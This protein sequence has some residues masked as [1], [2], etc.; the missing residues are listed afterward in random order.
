MTQLIYYPNYVSSHEII[1]VQ[2]RRN[3]SNINRLYEIIGAADQNEAQKSHT[4]GLVQDCSDYSALVIKLLQ[5]C[6]KTSI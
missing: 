6:S 5:S 2:R 3:L 1:V 4:D